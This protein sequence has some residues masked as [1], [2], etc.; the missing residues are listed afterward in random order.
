[1][2][3]WTCRIANRSFIDTFQAQ[4][5]QKEAP[6]ERKTGASDAGQVATERPQ[7]GMKQVLEEHKNQEAVREIGGDKL[8]CMDSIRLIC[9]NVCYHEPESPA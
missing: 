9:M 6:P 1:M 7:V 3:A 5:G 4:Q 2:C 8:T